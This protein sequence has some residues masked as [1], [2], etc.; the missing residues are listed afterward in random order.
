[1]AVAMPLRTYR[2]VLEWDDEDPN[3]HMW[4][5][6]VPALPGCFTQGHTQAQALERAQEAI[7]A[8][9]ES[10]AKHGEPFPPPDA[11]TRSRSGSRGKMDPSASGDGPRHAGGLAARQL[12]LRPKLRRP[13]LRYA[14]GPNGLRVFT[15]RFSVY[16]P[17]GR[18]G[19]RVC[20][21]T[22]RGW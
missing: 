18:P 20:S 21:A 7:S 19:G 4:V 16:A 12:R 3:N 5:V 15:P 22:N 11:E 1:M 13:D 14:L 9:L 6:T 8:Y 17:P 10:L 2:M